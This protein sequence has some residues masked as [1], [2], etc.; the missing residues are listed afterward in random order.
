MPVF[1]H[2]F[3]QHYNGKLVAVIVSGYDGDEA[4]AL[5]GKRKR[6]ASPLRRS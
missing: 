3:A 4:A 5:C 6:A 1:L 2:S